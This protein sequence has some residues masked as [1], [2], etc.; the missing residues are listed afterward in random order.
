MRADWKWA[1]KCKRSKL[2]KIGKAQT[3]CQT[4]VEGIP[5]DPLDCWG[6]E[7]HGH[8]PAWGEETDYVFADQN[9]YFFFVLLLFIYSI[10]CALS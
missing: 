8:G 3:L 7:G 6:G 9:V 10:F 4:G 2:R 1:T 5:E